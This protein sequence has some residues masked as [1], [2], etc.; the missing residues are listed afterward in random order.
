MKRTMSLKDMAEAAQNSNSSF[1][2]TGGGASSPGNTSYGSAMSQPGSAN[3]KGKEAAT[4]GWGRKIWEGLRGGLGSSSQQPHQLS[5]QQGG[6]EESES[7]E[8]DETEPEVDSS[9]EE[10]EVVK[11]VGK[12]RIAGGGGS[13]KKKRRETGLALF[14]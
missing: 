8:D 13:Q 7:D 2:V 9:E 10:K 1:A 5:Q 6:G 14:D 11:G 3:G 12:S 4:N